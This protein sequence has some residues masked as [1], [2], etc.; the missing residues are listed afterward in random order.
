VNVLSLARPC[1]LMDI[2]AYISCSF[3]R[4]FPL[5]RQTRISIPAH[6][7]LVSAAKSSPIVCLSLVY[8]SLNPFQVM[9]DLLSFLSRVR[10]GLFSFPCTILDVPLGFPVSSE[11]FRF[12]DAHCGMLPGLHCIHWANLTSSQRQH[13]FGGV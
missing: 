3:I 7:R 10:R 9:S 5:H 1:S 12:R 8:R 13:L 2:M 4:H 6:S 11:S